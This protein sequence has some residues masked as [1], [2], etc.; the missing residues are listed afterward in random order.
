[1]SNFATFLGNLRKDQL[2]PSFSFSSASVLFGV[3]NS[4]MVIFFSQK[5][6]LFLKIFLSVAQ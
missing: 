2:M 1:M 5:K 6:A 3:D 4:H